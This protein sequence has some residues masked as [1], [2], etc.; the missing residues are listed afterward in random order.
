MRREKITIIIAIN[1]VM[2]F[3]LVCGGFA[4]DYRE[5]GKTGLNARI[6]PSFEAIL[7]GRQ[8]GQKLQCL[9]GN[10]MAK[11]DTA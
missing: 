9:Y 1:G 2:G 4:H 7:T 10:L 11:T 3:I 8:S 6:D 5:E